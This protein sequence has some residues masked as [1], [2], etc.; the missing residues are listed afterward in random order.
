MNI[1][2]EHHIRELYDQRVALEMLREGFLAYSAGEVQLPPA[3]QFRFENADGDCCIKSAWITGSSSFCLKV[4]TGFYQNSCHGLPASDGLTMVFSAQTGQP[5]AL[6]NDHGWLTA[7]RTAL[8]GRIAAELLLPAQVERIAVFGTGLQAELQLRQ[9]LQLTPCHDVI[10]WGRRQEALDR[11]QD[12]LSDEHMR[13][14]TTLSAEEAASNASLIV[15]ATPSVSPLIR[16]EWIRPGTHITAI[17][18]DAPGKQELDAAILANAACILVDSVD[19]CSAYGELSHLP[20]ANTAKKVLELG[21]L[22][23]NR[24]QYH[25]AVRDITVA[26]LT[27]LGVQDAQIAASILKQHTQ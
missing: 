21:H 3:Q 12:K 19:Q 9:L 17:G 14:V 16:A 8:A 23:R 20:A 7:M 24:Q 22:L 6:L 27:G 18:A 4:S 1:L 10:V 11:F 5:L 15:T 13:L 26:D 2:S 25:R